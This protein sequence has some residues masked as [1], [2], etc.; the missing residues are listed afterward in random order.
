MIEYFVCIQDRYTE[1]WKIKPFGENE[2]AARDYY[3]QC[4]DFPQ[5][6]WTK[7]ALTCKENGEKKLIE[8]LS[9]CGK[10][11]RILPKEPEY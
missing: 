7:V 8:Q 11:R 6:L 5:L 3:K 1:K 10:E 9:L 4:F 2:Q